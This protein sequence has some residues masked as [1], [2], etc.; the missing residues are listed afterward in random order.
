MEFGTSFTPEGDLTPAQR[1]AQRAAIRLAQDNLITLLA[2]FQTNDVRRYEIIPYLVITVDSDALE[3]IKNLPIV[4]NIQENGK[5]RL[6]VEQSVPLIGAPAAWN[7]GFSGAGQAIAVLDTGVD[8]FHIFLRN[9]VISEACFS[10]NIPFENISSVCPG[11]V[12]RSTAVNSGLQC[13]PAIQGCDHGTHTAGIATGNYPDANRFGVARDAQVIAIQIF[14]REGD[15]ADCDP[16]NLNPALAP[17]LV[18]TDEDLIA[19]LERV[20]QLSQTYNISAV[21]LSIGDGQRNTAF[22]DAAEQ[23]TKA[24]ID[25]LRSYGIATV[26]ASGNEAYTNGISSP[27]CISS[28]V[29]VGS[30]QD[31]SNG[32][33]S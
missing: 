2:Q 7:R 33:N 16:I 12:T 17:C 3:F 20:Q 22:C 26:V 19:G 9:N 24:V 1:Q 29:S 31:G 15:V 30:T 5:N 6:T 28:A 21:N 8:K 18:N 14:S 32:H 23:S 10:S 4:V 11:G 27:A 13:N 25:V